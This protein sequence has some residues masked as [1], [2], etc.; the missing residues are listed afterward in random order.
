MWRRLVFP[1][2]SGTCHE[3]GDGR[4]LLL[5]WHITERCNLRCAH[6]Y[7]E[8]YSGAELS[9]NM[10]MNIICQYIE[11][12]KTWKGGAK[13]FGHI[14]L[15]G[16]E[17]FAREDFFEILELF[18]A[19]KKDFSFSILTN[20]SLIDKK[21]AGRLRSLGPKFVQ[22]SLEGVEATHDGIR[23]KGSY[24]KT[25]EAIRH[26]KKEGLR[27]LVSFTAHRAN[28]REFGA[29]AAVGRS[30]KVDRVWADRLI[31]AGAG[32]HMRS[33]AL[34]PVET[35]E[36]LEIMKRS[37]GRS[38]LTLFN[39][40]EVSMQRALQFLFSEERPYR[41]T[42]GDSLITIQSNG[43]L[44]PCRR[45]PIAAGNLTEATLADL[46]NDSE[47][48]KRLRDRSRASEGCESCL[49]SALCAGGLKCLS[50]AMTGSPFKADPGCWIQKK[51]V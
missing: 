2:Q 28:Y 35:K 19:H 14:T 48:F 22:V 23:G 30:L 9:F 50:Y 18:R 17:P 6:C 37:R 43:D 27:V 32:S 40:T 21:V 33:Q 51:A 29:V 42:A 31:P 38:I 13:R 15:S 46:Y 39:R 3:D 44:Y 26:L 41:C 5:Q 34:T 16:G 12:L 1:W 20:G 11:L 10:I 8:G 47:I 7:Q 25:V 36:F 24:A 49:Y 45:L 4:Q